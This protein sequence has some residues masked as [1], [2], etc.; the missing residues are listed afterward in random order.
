MSELHRLKN[1]SSILFPTDFSTAS[2]WVAKEAVEFCQI[3]GAHLHILH[4][5]ESEVVVSMY[6]HAL[7]SLRDVDDGMKE[8]LDRRLQEFADSLQVPKQVAVTCALRTGHMA[9]TICGYAAANEIDMI[10]MATQGRSGISHLIMGS[11]AERVVRTSTI[12]VLTMKAPP[13]P[14]DTP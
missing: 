1:L 7:D 14:E 12:P 2:Q 8:T 11:V 10:I 4:V 13:S 3:F 9:E 5:L 6:G